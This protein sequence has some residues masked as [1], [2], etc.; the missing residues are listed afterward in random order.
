VSIG[1]HDYTDGERRIERR[2]AKIEDVRAKVLLRHPAETQKATTGTHKCQQV[3]KMGWCM[4][5][6]VVA[7]A[8]ESRVRK[9]KN[10]VGGAIVVEREKWVE[11]RRNENINID[12][13]RLIQEI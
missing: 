13:H 11:V 1:Y 9:L 6:C 4:N 7:M 10:V 2:R 5:Q 8:A 12:T 3:A